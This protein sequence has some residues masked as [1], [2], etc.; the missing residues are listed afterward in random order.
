MAW[1]SGIRSIRWVPMSAPSPQSRFSDRVDDYVKY[2]PAYPPEI[3]D[4]FRSE[5]NLRPD[6]VIADVGAGTGIST[7]LFLGNGNPVYAIEPNPGMRNAAAKAFA[8][9]FHFQTIDG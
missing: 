6:H 2:R 4:I 5:M 7:R 3:L 8:D 1:S 9:N